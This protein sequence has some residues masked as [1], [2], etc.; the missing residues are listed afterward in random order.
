MVK[1][2]EEN[3]LSQ[4]NNFT[5]LYNDEVSPVYNKFHINSFSPNTLSSIF[6]EM[7]IA[8]SKFYSF[9]ITDF[10]TKL[11]AIM[12]NYSNIELK[13]LINNNSFVTNLRSLFVAEFNGNFLQ[14]AE[15]IKNISLD[16][17][18]EQQRK[19][20]AIQ[21]FLKKLPVKIKDN[22]KT[23]SYPFSPMENIDKCFCSIL[24]NC[25]QKYRAFFALK[26]IRTDE[27]IIDLKD[28]KIY[29][30]KWNFQESLSFQDF[31]SLSTAP[32]DKFKFKM[33]C[34]VV[35]SNNPDDALV[36]AKQRCFD[37]LSRI[38]YT[39][40]DPEKQHA[41]RLE[42]YHDITEIPPKKGEMGAKMPQPIDVVKELFGDLKDLSNKSAHDISLRRALTWFA[43]GHYAITEYSEFLNYWLSLE[44]IIGIVGKFSTRRALFIIIFIHALAQKPEY[45]ETFFQQIGIK[46]EGKEIDSRVISILKQVFRGDLESTSKQ[47]LCF[48]EIHKDELQYVFSRLF[49]IQYIYARRNSLVH[50]GET[51][52]EL[53]ALSKILEVF[54][55]VMISLFKEYQN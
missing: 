25:K 41:L 42:A 44:T 18:S 33:F 30:D 23:S 27:S 29:N 54:T 48:I 8:I 3:R 2:L 49:I 34:D 32:I 14:L 10:S 43:E 36:E 24:F 5:S 50:E 9:S 4:F 26:G 46:V 7:L 20:M 38:T 40:F 47:M 19:R 15:I 17:L 51:L 12:D 21:M 39:Y 6:V 55:Q 37:A 11:K 31:F 16:R 52:F 53:G 13:D 1:F 22:H 45:L 35:S 28:V